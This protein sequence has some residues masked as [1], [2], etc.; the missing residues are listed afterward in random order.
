MLAPQFVETP[1]SRNAVT[2]WDSALSMGLLNIG[3]RGSGKTTLLALLA[4]QQLR[5]GRAQVIIDPLGTLSEALL[6]LVLRSLQRVPLE[7]HAAVWQKV[8]YID[9]GNKDVVTPFPIYVQREGESLWETS[10]R[11][12]NVLELSHPNLLTQ[13]SITWPRARRVASNAGAVLASVGFQLTEVEDLLFNTLEWEKAGRFK[14][15]LKHPEAA[16]AVSYFRE[17]YLPL[18]RAEKHNLTGTFLDHVFRFSRIPSLRLLFGSSTQG[19]DWEEVEQQQQTVILDFK[20]IRDPAAKRFALLWIFNNLYEHMKQRGRRETSLG[21]LIDEFAALTQKVTADENPLAVLLDEFMQQYMRNHRIFFSCAFQSLNQI[22][23]QLRN[24]VLSLGTLVVGRLATMEEARLLADVLF[25]KDPFRVKHYRKVWGKD[26]PPPLIPGMFRYQEEILRNRR[27]ANPTYPY[28]VLDHEPEHM[29]LPEQLELAAQ[30]LRNLGVF[31]FLC[32]PALR[33]GEVS[34][35]VIPI[36]IA[37]IVRDRKTGEYVIPDAELVEQVRSRLAKR[38]GIPVATI[39]QEQEARLAGPIIQLPRQ[40]NADFQTAEKPGKSQAQPP[41]KT[42]PAMPV[43][44]SR[45]DVPAP[46]NAGVNPSLPALAGKEQAFLRFIIANPD[47]P[48]SVVYKELGVGVAQGTRLRE[49]LKAQGLVEELEVRTSSKAGG[50]PTK[51]LIPTFAALELFGKEAPAG[52]GGIL[53]RH[54]QQVVA[55]GATAKGYIARVEQQLSTGAIVDVYLENGEQRIAVEIAIASLPER[56]ISHM[57]NCLAYGYDQVYIIFAD[58][59]LLGRT[60]MAM[61]SAFSGE[62]LGKIRLLPLQQL[63]QVL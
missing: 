53:H 44:G 33:E 14:Q 39:R 27:Q 7:K 42:V 51:C 46:H 19:I 55:K 49:R 4:L 56:E 57:R 23:E 60:A 40:R 47:T 62:E 50:R 22:D 29:P 2:I 63:A 13:S 45:A 16:P 1:A 24:T 59:H 17:Q 12:L 18:T 38:S 52:R 3:A 28:Y 15:A 37:G 11:L 5:K 31:H 20:G 41:A 9:I 35:A 26:D 32:R 21:L 8:R 43:E 54:V 25:Q 6:H 36:S 61:Q 48:V 34:Q 30:E 10:D 58:E